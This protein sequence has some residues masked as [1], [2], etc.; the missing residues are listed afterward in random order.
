MQRKEKGRVPLYL[1]R[2]PKQLYFVTGLGCV[3]GA[4]IGSVRG[5]VTSWARTE[6]KPR[7]MA[8]LVGREA[9]ALGRQ[10]ALGA[11]TSYL[12]GLFLQEARQALGW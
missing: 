6:G 3:L 4:G 10:A 12:S 8:Y 2:D 1:E 7:G 11:A 9:E 5:L